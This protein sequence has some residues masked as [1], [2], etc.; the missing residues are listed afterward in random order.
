MQSIAEPPALDPV[1]VRVPVPTPPDGAALAALVPAAAPPRTV[2]DLLQAYARD[3]LPTKAAKTQYQQGRLHLRIVQDIGSVAL[4]DLSPA[5]LRAWRDQLRERFLAPSTVRQYLEIMS[6]ALRMAVEECDWLAE[7]PMKKVRRP[8]A[9]PGRLRWLSDEER[10]RLLAVCQRSKNPYLYTL[11]YC[12]LVTGMR[13]NELKRLT[14]DQLDL[15]H[16]VIR[17]SIT[18][19]GTARAIPVCGEALAQLRVLHT[20]RKLGSP[21][22]F[23]NV[24]GTA[25]LD[26]GT[27]WEAA[28]QRAKLPDFRFHDLRHTAASYLAMSGA[29]M[30]EL[31]AILGHKTLAMTKRYVHFSQPHTARVVQRMVAERLEGPGS[32]PAP[33]GPGLCRALEEIS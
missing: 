15:Q 3:I 10:E 24:C 12:A 9:S 23:A 26:F 14:W 33:S 16:G 1:D 19:N 17:L 13:K 22:V 25:P 29:T 30:L 4:Q 8:P 28:R 11:V 6:G 27:A 20:Q 18:K 2:T 7:N 5:R 32:R 21:W 31:S